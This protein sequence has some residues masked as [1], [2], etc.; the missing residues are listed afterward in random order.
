MIIVFVV[1][2]SISMNQQ[3]SAGNMTVLDCAKALI[4]HFL[5]V[6]ARTAPLQMR[7]DRYF[8]TSTADSLDALKATW[9]DSFGTFVSQLKTLVAKDLGDVGVAL[10]RTFDSL[11]QYRLHTGMDSFGCGRTPT[12][13]EPTLI[14]ALSDGGAL[15][16]NGV[17]A[18]PHL[19]LPAT[20]EPGSEFVSEPFRWD[21]RLYALLLPFAAI[22]APDSAAGATGTTA[23]TTT[24]TTT[25]TTAT[26]ASASPLAPMC[27]VTGGKC[28][29]AKSLRHALQ[30]M[31]NLAT[32]HTSVGVN[33]LLEPAAPIPGADA[34]THGLRRKLLIRPNSP[35]PWWPI[36]ESY[37]RD[38][39]AG[40]KQLPPRTALPTIR[41]ATNEANPA[42]PDNFPFDKYELEASPLTEH[43]L[44][45]T[46]GGCLTCTVPG[47]GA[48]AGREEPFGYLKASTTS[49]SVSLFVLPYNYPRLF[50]LINELRTTHRMVP[51]VRWRSD[52]EQYY[53]TIPQY[54]APALRNALRVIG[55]NLVPE[56]WDGLPPRHVLVGLEQAK[57]AAVLNAAKRM[58]ELAAVRE[59]IASGASTAEV[60]AAATAA[61]AAVTSVP[62]A[63]AILANIAS[64]GGPQ[65]AGATLTPASGESVSSSLSQRSNA[66]STAAAAAAAAASTTAGAASVYKTDRTLDAIVTAF[67]ASHDVDTDGLPLAPTALQH[68]VAAGGNHT[69]P[70]S[71]ALPLVPAALTRNDLLLALDRLRTAARQP[72]ARA[73]ADALAA[74]RLSMPIA[75]MGD[76]SEAM[77]RN[78]PLRDVDPALDSRPMF[79]NPFRTIQKRMPGDDVDLALMDGVG[80]HNGPPTRRARPAT[81]N[82]RE[83]TTPA[84]TTPATLPPP[85]MLLPPP[86]APTAPTASTHTT[87]S[88]PL[89]LQQQQQ[90]QASKLAPPKPTLP[91][92]SGARAPTPSSS[93]AV[94]TVAAA[95]AAAAA[96]NRKRL[97]A[98]E[99]ASKPAVAP[100]AKAARVGGGSAAALTRSTQDEDEEEEEDD[101]Q[102]EFDS[103]ASAFRAGTSLL[104]NVIFDEDSSSPQGSPSSPPDGGF[105]PTA[106]PSPPPSPPQPPS[107]ATK[108]AAAEPFVR[109]PTSRVAA[110]SEAAA[111]RA[112]KAAEKA[113][114]SDSDSDS[115]SGTSASGDTSG[116]SASGDNNSDSSDDDDDDDDDDNSDSDS[117]DGDESSSSG[118]ADDSYGSGNSDSSKSSEGAVI[119]L[120]AKRP[121]GR[122]PKSAAKSVSSAPK[123][124]KTAA[125]TKTKTV[126]KAKA[127]EKRPVGR[128]PKSSSAKTPTKSTKK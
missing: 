23:T 126:T 31:E 68:A 66:T 125:A 33:V 69:A 55:A 20:N 88:P 46:R 10:Q 105:S 8:L 127:T 121:R 5:K 116:T 44:R 108:K 99:S 14:V 48:R 38:A 85:S 93:S 103:L 111:A 115:T 120:P 52:F 74:A 51:T 11:N 12:F 107:S 25:T 106:P 124:A 97:G 18:P 104:Q 92:P 16:S 80:G 41:F 67:G 75:M 62:E 40:K 110:M 32:R 64:L 22:D 91:P 13:L 27:E 114:R 59:A 90:Q 123:R 102:P 37:S 89:P 4:E 118:R 53:S 122:P 128:P 35:H 73:V 117:D 49:G 9:R 71:T 72:P 100:I 98:P 77:V 43:M 2:T 112:K 17:V 34:F 28:I 113:E 83:S 30:L 29:T 50:Q 119:A 45:T 78:P 42:I 58:A 15:L 60:A 36:P 26:A 19:T 82:L 39:L 61:A 87:P 24:T 1:D 79:G 101:A 63:D 70:P 94:A 56:H 3:T 7:S 54:Y 6:R 84:E 86:T 76:Y 47:S 57:A 96:A 21:Q 95:A 109:P 81:S 65:Q